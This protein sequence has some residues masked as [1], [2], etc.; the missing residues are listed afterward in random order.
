MTI[1]RAD[2][3]AKALIGRITEALESANDMM[4]EID[5]A[6]A[7]IFDGVLD[8]DTTKALI[9]VVRNAEAGL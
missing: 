4:R 9:G 2:E 7:L 1:E 6:R 5:E 8:V 3:L